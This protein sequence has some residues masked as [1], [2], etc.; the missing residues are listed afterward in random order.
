MQNNRQNQIYEY[1]RQQKTVRVTDLMERYHVA[2]MT[3]RRDLIKLEELGLI[4]RFHGGANLL[5][6]PG[7]ESDFSTRVIEN[8]RAKTTIAQKAAGSITDGMTIYIDGSTTCHELVKRLPADKHLTVFTDSVEA[9]IQL[10]HKL[11]NLSVFVI[12]GELSRDLNTMDGHIA[13]ETVQKIYVDACF[14][15]CGGFS[16]DGI[17]NT[18]IIGT[19]VKKIILKHAAK[20]ILLADSSKYD[21]HGLCMLSDWKTV[22]R[23]ITDDALPKQAARD[24]AAQGVD[25]NIA[26]AGN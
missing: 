23:L 19:Q 12:G 18:G 22:G 6:D 20:N 7:S 9:L 10:R 1:I 2:D 13:V 16:P 11:D 21:R 26:K 17:T 4:A 24:L 25:I 8:L 14:F 5:G 3:I 15:S